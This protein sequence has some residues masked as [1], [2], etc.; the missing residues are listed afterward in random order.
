[1]EKLSTL[2]FPFVKA[3]DEGTTTAGNAS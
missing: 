3:G 1:M 2:K